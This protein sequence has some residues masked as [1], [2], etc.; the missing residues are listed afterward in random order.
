[1]KLH[2]F[3]AIVEEI[4]IVHLYDRSILDN[5]TD[6]KQSSTLYTGVVFKFTPWAVRRPYWVH[7][8]NNTAVADLSGNKCPLY[9]NFRFTKAVSLKVKLFCNDLPKTL[10]F[11]A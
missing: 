5:R 6:C 8:I 3:C 11:L 1:M 9:V 7:V 2:V 4:I 10:S